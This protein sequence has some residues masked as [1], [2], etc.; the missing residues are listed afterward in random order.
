M[1]EV[2][3]GCGECVDVSYFPEQ[4]IWLCG[5]CRDL[6]I[7]TFE[8]DLLEKETGIQQFLTKCRR[9][10]FEDVEF[11]TSDKFTTFVISGHIA[12]FSTLT[13]ISFM[14]LEDGRGVLKINGACG[15]VIF[16]SDKKTRSTIKR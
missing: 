9:Y 4:D 6:G 1:V 5:K 11:Y 15:Y 16:W 2:C 7:E 12:D 13:E 3:E 14:K 10:G 8:I